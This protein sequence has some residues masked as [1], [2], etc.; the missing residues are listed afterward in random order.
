MSYEQE[1]I[2][3]HDNAS[4]SDGDI[5]TKIMW[6]LKV[7]QCR[8][9]TVL[10]VICLFILV[11]AV[12]Y[13]LAIRRY[14]STAKLLIIEQKQDHISAV[15]DHDSSGNTMA[16]HRELVR[17]S[18]VLQS[19]I[20]SLAPEH[21]IDLLGVAP[22]KWIETI[23]DRLQ[24]NTTRKTNFIEVSYQS[25]SPATATAVVN[26]TIQSYLRFI[27][28]THKGTAGDVIKTLTVEREKLR[29]SLSVKQTELQ[30]FR[31]KVGHITVSTD[32]SMVEPI[33]QRALHLN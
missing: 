23:A 19:A 17:S 24:A 27:E 1:D 4:V 11:G 7:A 3:A 28:K 26:A 29:K 5:I 18:V 32:D 9:N 25:K 22:Q 2:G 6:F 20:Q 10:S 15:G 31:K 13:S 33:V 21:R 14:E 12:Y 30:Q 16:T 8:K